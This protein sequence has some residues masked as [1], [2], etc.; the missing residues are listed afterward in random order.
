VTI[1]QQLLNLKIPNPIDVDGLCGPATVSAIEAVQRHHLLI[2]RP[3]GMVEPNDPTFDFLARD[4]APDSLGV[5]QIAWGARVS[6]AFK[7]KL[8]QIAQS[9]GVDPDYLISAMA[10][11]TGET[12][13]PSIRNR[14]GATGL[15]QFTPATA[16]ELSTNTDDLANMTAEDQMDFVEKYFDPYKSMLETIEDVYMAILWPAAIGKP[17]SWVLFS[18]PSP[19]YNRNSGLD[20][21]KDGNVTKEEAA[22]MIRAKLRKGRGAGYFG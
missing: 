1:L 6:A 14:S 8:I 2:K 20:A 10:F 17:N 7:A 22:A 4:T 16:S 13:N 19:E 11:E 18:K 21:D 3:A 5:Y 9:I 15:I 12:F